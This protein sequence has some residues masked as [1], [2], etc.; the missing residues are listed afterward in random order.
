MPVVAD[1]INQPIKDT[2]LQFNVG[3]LFLK[4]TNLKITNGTFINED[5]RDKDIAGYFDTHHLQLTGLNATFKD[6]SLNKDTLRADMD[7][8]CKERC[9]LDLKKLKT[10]LKC[11]PQIIELAKLDLQTNKSRLTDYYAMH[12]KHLAQDFDDYETNVFMNATFKNAKINSDDIAFFAPPLHTWKKEADISGNFSGTV[13]DFIFN[14]LFARTSGTT[15]SGKL[16]MK[17]LPDINKT[18]ITFNDGVL[19]TNFADLGI[20]IPGIRGIKEPNFEALGP[21]IYRGSFNG[22]IS[23]FIAKGNASTNLGAMNLD[24]AMQFFSK[25]EPI[26]KGTLITN[27]FNLGKFL[28]EPLLGALDFNGKVDG[29]GFSLDKIATTFNGSIAHV[30]FNDYTYNDIVI[31]AKLE[32]NS[33]NGSL[34]VNDSNFNFIS[35]MEIDFSKGHDPH[36]NIVGDL[37]S[38]NLKTLNFTNGK[39]KVT[40]TLDVNFTGSNIDNFLGSAKFLN[41]NVK[42]G[43]AEISFDSLSLVSGYNEHGVKYLHVA[44]PDVSSTITGQF[45]ILDLPNSFQSFLHRYYPA[46]IDVPASVPKN[47]D[48]SVTINTDYI[49]PYLQLFDVKLSGLND[50]QIQGTVDTRNDRFGIDMSI[51]YLKYDKYIFSGVGI[52]GR[53]NMDSLNLTGDIASIQLSDSMYLPSTKISINA[54][55]DHS[56]VSLKTSASNTLNDAS[57]LADVYTLPDGVRV[58]FRPSTFV[59]NEKKW[60]VE[61]DGELVIRKNYASAKNVRFTQGFQEITIETKNEE[62]NNASN[63][64]MKLSNVV[65]GDF[66]SLFVKDYRFEGITSGDVQLKNFF[67]DFN[68]DAQLKVEQFR[69]DDD[70]IG[71]VNVAA[72]YDSKTGNLNYTFLSPNEKYNFSAKGS[73]KFKDKKSTTPIDNTIHLV[74]TRLSLIQRYLKG[75]F[76]NIDGY[77]NGDLRISGKPNSLNFIGDVKIHDAGMLVDY[78]QVFYNIDSALIKF[79]ED[80]INCGEFGIRDKFNNKGIVRGKLYEKNFKNMDF[81]FDLS[82][83]KLLLLDTKS[84]DNQMF[85]GKAIG[86]ATLAFKGPQD[87]CKMTIV[88]EANDTSHIFIPS[89]FAKESGDADFIVFKKVGTEIEG[90]E[91][92]GSFNMSVDLDLTANN[93]VAIDVILDELTGDVIEATGNGRLHIKAG[94]AEKLD[95]RGRYNIEHGQYAF[96]FQSLIKKPF[97][98]LADAGNFIEWKGD[99]YKA[100]IHVDAR[101]KAENVSVADLI[102]NQSFTTSDNSI[103]AYRGE[104]YVIAQLRDKLNQPTINFKIDFPANSPIKNDPT[105][106]QFLNR[107]ESDNNEML[108]QATS[109]IIFN[110]FTPYGQGLLSGGGVNYE[111]FGVNSISQKITAQLNK[112]ISNILYKLFKDKSIRFDLGTSVYS[113]STLLGSGVNSSTGRIDMTSVVFKVAKSFFNDNV[114]V[115]FG[116]DLNFNLS[117]SAAAS[118][119]FQWLPDL[120]VE[121]VLSKDK[122]LRAIIFN[123]NSLDIST[124]NALG[125]RNRQGV[126]ISYTRSFDK[127]FGSGSGDSILIHTGSR[128]SAE[129]KKGADSTLPAKQPDVSGKIKQQG[130]NDRSVAFLPVIEIFFRKGENQCNS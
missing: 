118:G 1:V 29:S 52:A 42:N 78:T 8:S 80:G 110:S 4:L 59:L 112:Q 99:P 127:L 58:Q 109:L 2:G 9:G 116:G 87:D 7:L 17:G 79:E 35:N 32:K 13:S 85:Y 3:R 96:N 69:V 21:I 45:S 12:F 65:L 125:R 90:G 26:Y 44:T 108:T 81:D 63:L 49:E 54:A 53:G 95:I 121:I 19:Q 15:I 105:F 123:K 46:Y 24:I 88:G 73:Y 119:N 114:I 10:K 62:E 117:A 120:N 43:D 75:I 102:S 23:N 94:T 50:A 84:K 67:G 39:V 48:F 86:K 77:A 83:N 57:L 37:V 91:E 22:L 5:A 70:S 106:T 128:K 47:Q 68:A 97:E 71:L 124:N 89:N 107:I 25:K 76:S 122:K 101:Y 111:S 34:K 66:T 60:N 20:F 98:L 11:T 36:F 6:L 92:E 27:H 14:N 100:D 38:S 129:T 64:K 40:G 18:T 103:R 130:K 33:F 28:S 55:N 41:A 16:A 30:D 74:N 56:V 93:K 61:K 82:T 72:D 126:S 104:V 31:D 51:P 113:S 115:T